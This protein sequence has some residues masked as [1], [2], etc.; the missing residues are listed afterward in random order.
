EDRYPILDI[1]AQTPAIPENSQWCMFLRNHDELTLEMVTDEERDTMYRAYAHDPEARINLGIRHRLAPLLYNDRR[2]IE[3]MTGLLFSLPGTPVLYY[4]DE[5]GMGDNIYLGDRNGV[6]TPMQWSS[7]RNAG[8]STCNPQKLY[9]PVII[10][11]EYHYEAINVESQQENPSS[12]L[13]WVKRLI[14]LRKQ[15]LAFGRGTIEFL[16]PDNARILAFVRRYG[17]ESIL[18]V[19]NL[20]RFM[21][22][23]DLDLREFQG[24]A[25]EEL[26]GHSLLPPVDDRP[27][28]LTLSAYGFYWFL[29]KPPEVG[30]HAVDREPMRIA[31]LPAVPVDRDWRAELARVESVRLD[32][33]LPAF[34]ER[35]R[36]AGLPRITAVDVT[37]AVSDPMGSG[38]V[39][40]LVV[41]AELESGDAETNILPLMLVPEEAM[42]SLLDPGA[43]TF[44]ARAVE[45]HN[46]VLC[47]ALA[48]P[49]CGEE[50][51]KAIRSGLSVSL[52]DGEL[53]AVPLRGLTEVDLGES[54]L[55]P[56]QL[57]RSER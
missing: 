21:Q 47:D 42:G 53:A 15:H 38:D 54:P 51:V 3:L 34:L 44:L 12:L 4:G 2:R 20:S 31:D 35:R 22:F 48:V 30:T 50:I 9:F 1:L 10:D 23:V 28:R 24:Y 19:A 45:N 6:R 5:I 13:W 27:Y 8:F 37:R 29:L 40:W 14:A 36:P 52:A 57:I 41:R 56:T 33:M 32:P 11:P 43:G 55:V 49:S 7:D 26:S 46:G 39:Q 17:E 25:P 18:V 16:R